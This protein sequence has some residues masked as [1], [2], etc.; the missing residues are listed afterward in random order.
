MVER[1][2]ERG[3]TILLVTHF[4]EEAER[5]ADRVLLIDAGR[6]VA[7]GTPA[8]LAARTTSQ[9]VRFSTAD[10]LPAGLLEAL[11]GV[12]SVLAEGTDYEVRGADV[13]VDVVLAVTGLGIRPQ[14][15]R[16]EQGSLE[17]AFVSIVAGGPAA[18]EV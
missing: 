4:M 1:I 8:Q 7:E 15:L 9:T 11:P 16:V 5:L 10:P 12:A 2:R 17:E 18:K 3:V 6:V 13:A 14:H